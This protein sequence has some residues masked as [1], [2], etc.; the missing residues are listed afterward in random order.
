MYD[1]SDYNVIVNT[2][3]YYYKIEVQ[4]VCSAADVLGREGSSILLKS[5]QSE[6]ANSLKWT[7]YVD[8]D[9]GVEKYVIEKLNAYGVWEEVE[10]VSG[11]VTEWEEK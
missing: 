6:V 1:Y 8:W 9:L 2:Y 3:N 5:I 10:T 4:N 11:N 7:R